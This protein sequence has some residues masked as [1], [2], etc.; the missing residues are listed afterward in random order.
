MP[1]AG[2]VAAIRGRIFRAFARANAFS[3]VE[4][5]TREELG[6]RRHGRV[7]FRRMVRRGRII[8]AADGRYYMVQAYYD[9]HMRRKKI[10]LPIALAILFGTALYMIIEALL[11][12]R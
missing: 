10:A 9:A 5:K 3:E 12:S 2:A 8:E 7:I 1:S 4:A 11:S 6:L